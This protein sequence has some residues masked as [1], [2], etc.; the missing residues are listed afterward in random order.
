M[1]IF[2]TE[3]NV[4]RD[5]KLVDRPGTMVI[6]KLVLR[7]FLIH[8]RHANDLYI[9]ITINGKGASVVFSSVG[10]ANVRN[11]T[12]TLN[13]SDKNRHRTIFPNDYYMNQ[14]QK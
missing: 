7:C 9:G 1:T 4:S 12:Y 2:F 3:C 11:I 13:K 8:N 14:I 5:A 10:P 6:G